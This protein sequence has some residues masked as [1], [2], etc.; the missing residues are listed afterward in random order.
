LIGAAGY[1]ALQ[2]LVPSNTGPTQ[3]EIE[4]QARIIEQQRL[5]QLEEV[6]AG[7]DANKPWEQLPQPIQ[8]ST[9]CLAAI[10]EMPL[11]PAGY[12]LTDVE[13][14][15]GQ[16]VGNYNRGESH[17][18]WLREWGETN[19]TF[20]VDVDLETSNGF[21]SRTLE[22]TPLR[23]PENLD[24]FLVILRTLTETD[25][26][27]EG[28]L[29]YTQPIQYVYEEYPEYIPLYG[30]SDLVITTKEPEQ[31]ITALERVPGIAIERV[32][33]NV[34]DNTYTFEGDIYVKNREIDSAPTMPATV[35]EE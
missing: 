2:L 15:D 27:I 8:L 17:P 4:A 13:C 24:N 12:G 25:L 10:K 19:P 23:G 1:I 26:Y 34:L 21:L 33:L 31:W 35:P 3:E 22:T 32:K 28:T 30:T 9:N 5:E 18:S 16:I 20:A 7:F 29:T 6:Y 14:S 11:G